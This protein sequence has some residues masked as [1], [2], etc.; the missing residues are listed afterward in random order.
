MKKLLPTILLSLY[1]ISVSGQIAVRD[2][3]YVYETVIVYDTIVIRDT[4]RIKKTFD[5]P[6]LQSQKGLDLQ[7]F[8]PSTK[9]IL[10]ATA[11]FPKNR[12]I[13]HESTN[14]NNQK[15]V[16]IMKMNVSKF[17][18]AVMISAQSM[19]NI[20]AQEAKS[21]ED[22]STFPMQ[23]SVVYPMSVMGEKTVNYR[24]NFSLNMFSGKVGAVNGV[25]VGGF[26][27]Q[28]V[29]NVKGAQIA[30][31]VNKT[32]DLKGAQ[33]GGLANF[34][35]TVNGL[36]VGGI[37]NITQ[38]MRGAQIGG[39]ANITDYKSGI[40]VAGIAN[41]CK[42]ANDSQISGIVS[43]SES[44]TGAQIS[45]I[46]N[47]TEK[48]TGFQCAGIANISNEISGASIAGICNRT[49]T[50]R[51]FQLGLVNV[52]DSIEK[53]FSIALINIV[54][55]DFYQEWQL[56]S[57]DYL[58][59][60]FSYK[61][62]WRKLYTIFAAGANFYD[63]KL[64]AIGVGVGYRKNIN[65]RF[66]FQPEIVNYQYYPVDFK[67]F[68][69]TSSTHLKFGFVLNINQKLGITAAPSIYSLNS[70]LKEGKQAY[71]IS[72]VKEVF[73]ISDKNNNYLYKFGVGFNFGVI[74]R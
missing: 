37:V 53:G 56:S 50:L 61:M 6:A 1:Y 17:L 49:G 58:N 74:I 68:L 47:I 43:M 4:I 2:T 7:Y 3:I 64:W 45:G 34:S 54:K 72:P 16:K 26:F 51:G 60:A 8:I 19:A 9:K 71:K 12:I 31:L 42:E 52:I 46:A 23:M 33:I 13:L 24:Y 10:M 59:V 25:E 57:A 21:E 38:R 29:Q 20:S 28:A 18:S 22:L 41:I 70:D 30:G 14:K 27:N 65:Y 44:V 40:Q 5:M 48:C 67:N 66:D 15:N 73:S 55:T 69:F 32:S 62:G 63:V 39:I 36:Q 11:T 35:N